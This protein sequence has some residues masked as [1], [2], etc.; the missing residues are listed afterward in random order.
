MCAILNISSSCG[1]SAANPRLVHHKGQTGHARKPD[2]GHPELCGPPLL[3]ILLGWLLY[4][5]T[6]ATWDKVVLLGP[7]QDEVVLSTCQAMNMRY[8]S[9]QPHVSRMF[10]LQIKRNNDFIEKHVM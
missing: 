5:Q 9:F 2:L 8:V 10:L 7:T 3:S 1:E 6:G 4:T